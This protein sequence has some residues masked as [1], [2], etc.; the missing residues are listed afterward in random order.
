MTSQLTVRLRP[1]IGLERKL[2]HLK[3]NVFVFQIFLAFS[4]PAHLRM[5]VDNGRDAIVINVDG[6]TSEAFN[7]DYSLV[8]GFVREHRSFYDVTDSVY[9]ESKRKLFT[10]IDTKNRSTI[11]W[12][13]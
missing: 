2:S 13:F 12:I 8:F 9:T 10:A 7:T 11:L 3:R 1:A 4:D 6:G 5:G